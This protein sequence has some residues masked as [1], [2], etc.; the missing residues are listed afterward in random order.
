ML[1]KKDMKRIVLWLLIILFS[2]PAASPWIQYG[3]PK[4]DDATWMIIRLY[5]AYETLRGADIPI[6]MIA[7]L[8]GGFGYPVGQF[9][10][11]LYLYLGSVLIGV[12]TGLVNSMKVLFITGMILSGLGMYLLVRSYTKQATSGILA[13]LV[14]LYGPYHL[15]TASTR[16][17]IGEVLAMA[18]AP[19]LFWALQTK[20]LIFGI[21]VGALLILSHN[22]YAMLFLVV[23]MIIGAAVYRERMTVWMMTLIGS[24]GVSTFFWIPALFERDFTVF[25]LVQVVD[26][27]YFP[28]IFLFGIVSLTSLGLGVIVGI[29]RRSY[30]LLIWAVIGTVCTILATQITGFLWAN[31]LLSTYIQF[32][33]RF[34]GISLFAAAVCAGYLLSLFAQRRVVYLAITAGVIAFEATG[35]LMPAGYQYYEDI[36]YAT[37]QSTTTVRDEYTP[38]WTLDRSQRIDGLFVASVDSA[39]ITLVPQRGLSL[40]GEARS[41]VPFEL[42]VRRA[43]FPGWE[44]YAG[45]Q[46][47]PVSYS[48]PGGELKISMPQ[49]SYHFSIQFGETTMRLWS[50]TV[51][52]AS[53][54]SCMAYGVMIWFKKRRDIDA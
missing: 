16:G 42:T 49:G 17:N 50:N 27:V 22:I 33:F 46:Q 36:W 51:S 14:Y 41:D 31:T 45:N 44:A 34:L 43:Y 3:F 10:Y 35:Y 13:S 53:I 18:I 6:R 30:V 4:T 39:D 38:R 54:L 15:W 5:G 32:P 25:S 8:D 24:L 1:E 26:D 12:G 23:Y 2:L 40:K 9:L 20:R 11:P 29:M 21:A 52:I 19:F 47:L 48:S 28:S 7:G 37:N